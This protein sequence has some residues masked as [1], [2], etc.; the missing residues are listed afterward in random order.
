MKNFSRLLIIF[1][2]TLSLNPVFSQNFLENELSP[3]K[4]YVLLAHPTVANI[5]TINFLLTNRILQLPE[6]EFIGIYS[7][8]ENYDYNQSVALLKKPEMSKFHLQKVDGVMSLTQIFE[9]NEWTTTF[10][11]LFDHSVGVFFFGGP[12]IQ[13]EIY[14]QKNLY[15]VVTDPNRHLFELSFLFHLLGGYQ[16]EQFTPFLNEKP[17]YFVTGFCLG[18]QSMN[19]ATGGSLIQDIPAQTY[20]KMNAE[21]TLKL[22]KDQLHRNYWQEITKETLLMDN[23]FHQIVYT[24]NPFFPERV[25]ADKNLKPLVLSAHHQSIDDLGKNL[26]VTATSM[27]GQVIEGIR[28]RLYENVFAVQFH[29]EVSALYTEDKK[30][31]FAPTDSPRSFFEILSPEDREFHVKYWETISKAIKASIKAQKIK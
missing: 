20:H 1:V 23:S 7:V 21:E 24:A 30:L 12:D 15:S 9:Q 6:V 25:K 2:L 26:I 8:A 14:K 31:K 19:V 11:K 17:S 13:P 27:D 18:L 5:E 28:H 4:S 16:N 22:N 29:P 3:N 10:K